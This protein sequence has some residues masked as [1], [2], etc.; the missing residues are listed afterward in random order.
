MTF[1]LIKTAK[2]VS[3]QCLHHADINLGIVMRQQRR[4][5]KRNEIT[6]PLNVKIEQF[7]AQ[8]RRQIGFGVEQK[9]SNIVLKRPFA[10]AL[11]VQ[12][13]RLAAAQHDIWGLKNPIEEEI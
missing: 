12:K 8:C 5:V 9:R 7:L 2:S 1:A 10:P 3:S 13:E 4:A 11:V 6:N